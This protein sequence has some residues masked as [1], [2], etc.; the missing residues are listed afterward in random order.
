MVMSTGD[1]SV[2]KDFYTV[3]LPDGSP[4]DIFEKAF[5]EIEESA[6]EAFRRI[7]SGS[8]PIDGEHREALATWIALQHL[9][10]E[11]VRSSQGNFQA[12]MI[13]LIV[14]VS[15]KEALRSVIQQAESRAV[16]DEE[17]DWEWRDI[18][19]P[20]GPDLVPDAN[21]HVRLLMGLLAGT[22]AY[23]RDSH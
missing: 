20:G 13:R 17:L 4:S 7:L 14:G 11:D 19:K 6:A 12:E 15:G 23:L 18:T 9:R 5:S 22:S 21:Q 3:T 1:A 16:S 10:S 2:I 8:W